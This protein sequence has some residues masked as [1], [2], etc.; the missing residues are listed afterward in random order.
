MYIVVVMVYQNRQVNGPINVN[1]R[2]QTLC[3]ILSFFILFRCGK[4]GT[5]PHV[6]QDFFK[7]EFFSKCSFMF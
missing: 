4:L 7:F 5:D 3:I 1:I 6:N 2:F